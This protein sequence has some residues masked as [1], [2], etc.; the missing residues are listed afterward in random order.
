MS[1][2]ARAGA[3]QPGRSADAPVIVVDGFLPGQLAMAMRR[4]IDAHFAKPGAHARE[5]HQVWNYWYVPE[6]YTYLRTDADRVIGREN[7]SGF[8]S[9]LRQ[10]STANLGLADVTAAYLSLYVDGC[11][12]GWHNDSLNGRFAFVY[13]L[14][15]NERRTIGGETLVQREGDPFRSHLGNANAGRGFYET[16]EPRFN[17]LVVFDGR[18]PHAVERVEGS[19]DP[20][21]GRFVLHGHLR[22]AGAIVAGALTAAA[23]A[24]PLNKAL[25]RFAADSA[26]A[27]ALYHGILS[28][29]VTIAASGAVEA[30]DI[31]V[32][33]VIHPDPGHVE[34]DAV[35]AGLVARLKALKFAPSDGRT[36]L[37]QPLLFGARAPGPV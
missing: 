31:L 16:I 29:R 34:W 4:D 37:L 13:S 26:G 17:R 28:L 22:E 21:E 15:R 23:I 9:A 25:A 2:A 35:R 7:A 32:D 24:D 14:T 5:S 10:W 1:R 6:L 12:Q 11:R 33:R 30:C 8:H 36:V 19:M 18:L 20:V 27:V 3:K